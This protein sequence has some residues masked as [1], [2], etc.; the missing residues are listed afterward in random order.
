MK[1]NTLIIAFFAL[2]AGQALPQTFELSGQLRPRAEYKH[3]YRSLIGDG[4]DPAFAI[5]QRTRLNFSYGTSRVKTMLSVQDVRIW[6]DVATSNKSDLNGIMIHQAW[7]EFFLHENFSVKAGRQTLV[8]DDQR[9]F[10]NSDWNQQGRSHDALLLKYAPTAKNSIQFGFAYNQSS[11][12]DTGTFYSLEKN[13]KTLQYLYIHTENEGKLGMSFF[14]ANVGMPG[15]KTIDSVT[16]QVNRN[17][18]TLGPIFYLN[19]GKIRSNLAFYCQTGKNQKNIEKRAYFLGGEFN[20]TVRKAKTLGIGFQY[21]S[22]NDQVDA[23]AYDHEFSTLFG[24]GHKFNGWMD[25]FYAGSTHKGVGLL[26]VYIPAGMKRE[27]FSA[28]FQ[29]HYYRAAANVKDPSSSAESMDAYLGTEVG[30]MITYTFF[31]ELTFAAGYSQMFG[32]KTLEALKGGNKDIMQNWSWLM[33]TFNPVF[34]KTE[35]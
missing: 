21:L 18:Q 34:I 13:Y 19:R 28:D 12:K 11:D 14:L 31:P 35:K 22:G 30:I 7:G 27:K 10:G 2:L 4:V 3:G 33:L 5:S 15:S 9:L 23:D 26:D 8:Y 6:G 25:Y 20:Y 16:S 1:K 24:T 17:M 32:T 29:L